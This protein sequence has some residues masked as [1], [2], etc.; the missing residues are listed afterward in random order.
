LPLLPRQDPQCL[1]RPNPRRLHRPNL[2]RLLNRR[3]LRP[4]RKPLRRRL[5]V[6]RARL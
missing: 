2:P 6:L 1:R 4:S 3:R 5:S